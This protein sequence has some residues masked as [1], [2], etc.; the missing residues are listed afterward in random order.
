MKK[1]SSDGEF[2]FGIH[3]VYYNEDGSVKGY[4]ECSVVPTAPSIEEL[5]E[6]F[7]RINKA[8]S[9]EPLVYEG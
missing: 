2:V 6:K 1:A 5:S 3:E 9:K 7:G 4:S 8:L